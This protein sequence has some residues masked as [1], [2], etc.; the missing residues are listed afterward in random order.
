MTGPRRI[1]TRTK[2]HSVGSLMIASNLLVMMSWPSKSSQECLRRRTSHND[3]YGIFAIFVVIHSD[4]QWIGE[5]HRKQRKLLNPVFSIAHIRNLGT[6]F[7]PLYEIQS[8]TPQSRFF[9]GS[10]KRYRQTSIDETIYSDKCCFTARPG[11]GKPD[12][13]CR[14]RGES[15]RAL[16]DQWLHAS[17]SRLMSI[18]GWHE[19]L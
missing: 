17:T 12:I 4:S 1:R 8:Y 3:R 6:L 13:E 5:P 19:L 14:P 9:I 2:Y 16:L 7:S 10:P 15:W 18:G 11:D